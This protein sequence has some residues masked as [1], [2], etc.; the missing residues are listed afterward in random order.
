[1]FIQLLNSVL[2]SIYPTQAQPDYEA[3]AKTRATKDELQTQATNNNSYMLASSDRAAEENLDVNTEFY[4]YLLGKCPNELTEDKLTEF[5]V[6]KIVELI[7]TPQK[8]LVEMPAMPTSV[9]NL[10]QALS[11]PDFALNTLLDQVEKEPVVAAMLIKQANS[12]KYKRGLKPVS[13]IKTAFINLGSTGVKEGVLMGFIK[14][15]TPPSNVYFKLFGERIWLH[16]QQSAEY[17]RV[18]AKDLLDEEDSEIAY[19]VALLNQVGK[20]IIFRLMIDAFK[21]VDPNT[22]PNSRAL[23]ALMHKKAHELTLACAEFWQLPE[24][25]LREFPNQ[26]KTFISPY[27]ISACVA[28]AIDISMVIKLVEGQFIEA[29]QGLV[30][31]KEQ[32]L[33]DEAENLLIKEISPLI[34]G[35]QA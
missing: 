15:L 13:D 4:D 20:M 12:A 34:E 18:L 2:S 33:C 6:E 21:V 16:A 27:S 5:V 32:L 3:F 10:M 26:H 23:K 19:F 7:H 25:V 30:Y 11:D 28:Q 24:E 17:A 31:A 14:Q 8:I 29:R 35:A 9:T 1:M 22:P